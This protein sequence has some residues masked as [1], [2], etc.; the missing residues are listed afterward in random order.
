MDPL[1][2]ICLYTFFI[3]SAALSILQRSFLC[4]SQLPHCLN[5]V[6]WWFTP[7]TPKCLLNALLDF[8]KCMT[9]SG[10]INIWKRFCDG[11][12]GFLKLGILG[13]FRWTPKPLSCCA[14]LVYVKQFQGGCEIHGCLKEKRR[15]RLDG[16]F[17]CFSQ[18]IDYLVFPTTTQ[19]AKS[20]GMR[21]M[22]Q[23]CIPAPWCIIANEIKLIK[24]FWCSKIPPHLF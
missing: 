3:N 18:H 4:R 15:F 11:A 23:K 9:H 14:L 1:Y 10:K 17:G 12:T 2:S 8:V 13:V 19:I 16:F 20:G 22:L 24:H 6:T 7:G 5:I 21:T